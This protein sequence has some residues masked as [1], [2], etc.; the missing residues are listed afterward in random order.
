MDG[1][2]WIGRGMDEVPGKP[3]DWAWQRERAEI[4]A[5]LSPMERLGT[6]TRTRT[7]TLGS[8]WTIT[9]PEPRLKAA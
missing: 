5:A 3:T 4:R 8:R 2:R 9:R 6:A 7:V 1:E